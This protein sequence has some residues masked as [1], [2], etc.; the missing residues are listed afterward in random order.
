MHVA[1]FAVKTVSHA[2]YSYL[3][4]YKIIPLMV[5]MAWIASKHVRKCKLQ[6]RGNI[7]KIFRWSAGVPKINMG[8]E[9][10]FKVF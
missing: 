1:L 3:A 5:L 8:L 9:Q 2:V 10:V 7:F 6:K 4:A